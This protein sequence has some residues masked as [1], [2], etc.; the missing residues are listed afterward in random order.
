[1]SRA[2]AHQSVFAAIA[3]PTRRAILDL[4]REGERTVADL[5]DRVTRTTTRMTQPGFSQHLAVLRKA[6]LVNT[7]KSGTARIYRL[8]PRPLAQVADWI[9]FYDRF[10]DQ[11]L[12]RLEQHLA[13]QRP[14]PAK[15]AA[16]SRKLPN[17][18]S[19]IPQEGRQ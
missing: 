11:K 6:A 1:M 17:A 5:F 4:L 8:D 13:A 19:K 10:W 16:R 14:A 3:D 9:H 18:T 12:D 2:V 15:N 7:R